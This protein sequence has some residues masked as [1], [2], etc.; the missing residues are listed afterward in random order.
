MK[1]IQI[2]KIL[3]E[4]EGPNLE[5]EEQIPQS[6]IMAR[7]I[8]AFANSDGG[9]VLLGVGSKGAVIGVQNLDEAMNKISHALEMI[10]P[11]PDVETSVEKIDGK[12]VLVLIIHKSDKVPHTVKNLLFQRSGSTVVPVDS[13]SLYSRI[14]KDINT[15]KEISSKIERLTEIIE[16][17]NGQL[18]HAQSWRAKLPDMLIGGIIG[19]A[20]SLL[21]QFIL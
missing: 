5:F 14:T 12:A 9:M 3:S 15:Q 2:I 11:R 19:T 13:R 7:L 20:I 16:E 10:K 21:I 1:N 8:S 17:Q 18:V 6:N 4:P